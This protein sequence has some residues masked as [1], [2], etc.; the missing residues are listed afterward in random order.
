MSSQVEY[1]GAGKARKL[2]RLFGFIYSLKIWV[3]IISRKESCRASASQYG[4]CNCAEVADFL[5]MRK[6]REIASHKQARE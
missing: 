1:L 3:E 5:K 2:G 6:I 4:K